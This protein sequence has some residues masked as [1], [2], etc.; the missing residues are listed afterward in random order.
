MRSNGREV[1][2]KHFDELTRTELYDILRARSAVF[3]VEQQCPY[4]ELDDRDQEAIH[5]WLE[6]KDGLAAYLRVLK[7]G[8]EA[9]CFAIG[10]VVSA[11]RGRGLA[12]LLLQEGIRYIEEEFDGDRIYL[13]AQTYARGMYEKVGFRQVSEEFMM[14]GIPHVRMIRES[15]LE[16]E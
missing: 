5:L 7:P 12:R 16:E 13:E 9:D 10:R 4:A 6:D 11:R 15:S 2:V 14:D 3:V 8:V 1:V